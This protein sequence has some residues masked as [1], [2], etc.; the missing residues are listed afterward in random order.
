M[1]L[2][3]SMF[4]VCA[5]LATT[6]HSTAM[7]ADARSAALDIR[8]EGG[9]WGGV[10]SEAIAKTLHA[11][12]GVLL[13]HLPD[14]PAAPIVVTHTNGPPVTLYERGPGG[15]YLVHLHASGPRWHLYVYEFA[16]ELTHILSN[17]DRNAGA[18]KPRHNQWLEESLCETA[19]LFV[20]DRL[21][22]SWAQA[23]ESG[24][25]G[26]R[27]G[28]L[29]SFFETLVG[30]AHRQLPVGYGFSTW[31][32]ENEP[33]LRSDPYRRK[34]DDLIARRLLPLFE[35]MPGGWGALRYLNLD[36]TDNDASLR[37][38][39]SH[40]YGNAPLEHRPFLNTLLEV[41]Q[42]GQAAAGSGS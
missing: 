42:A 30:E 5:L 12:A 1:R 22:A 8:V 21:S 37:Q 32:A 33:G 27:A 36:A 39:L 25:L 40:W 2:F 14:A 31:L 3:V 10:P 34:Q 9:G 13:P 41:L 6:V 7:A 18:D 19:S 4:A 28:T 11:V 16:H 38:F 35:R 17:Y 23:G 26:G 24:E 15:E 29:R 20:L